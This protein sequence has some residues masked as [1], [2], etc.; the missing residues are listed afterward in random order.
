MIDRIDG[1]ESHQWHGNTCS[2]PYA[3]KNHK[4][5]QWTWRVQIEDL[6]VYPKTAVPGYHSMRVKLVE[7]CKNTPK[8]YMG[9]AKVHMIDECFRRRFKFREGETYLLSG[10]QKH[11]NSIDRW[12]V[13]YCSPNRPSP[14]HETCENP[15][16]DNYCQ[17]NCGGK[18]YTRG[19][20]TTLSEME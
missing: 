4:G 17:Y 11:I 13:D 7:A 16:Q 20:E 2:C 12:I 1:T 8:T 18:C 3:E 10:Y 15:A 19:S 6:T 14:Y 5:I 9:F